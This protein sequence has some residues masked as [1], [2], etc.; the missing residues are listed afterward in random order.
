MKSDYLIRFA[1]KDPIRL[2]NS[3][4]GREIAAQVAEYLANGGVITQVDH[5]ANRSHNQPIKRSRKE[6]I[7]EVKRTRGRFQ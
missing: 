4:A 5:T 7:L 1:D 6:Q 2:D 3:E